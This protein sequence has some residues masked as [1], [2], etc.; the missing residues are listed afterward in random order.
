MTRAC[1]VG[2]DRGEM[3]QVKGIYIVIF[4]NLLLRIIQLS[5][6]STCPIPRGYFW[7][8]NETSACH[9]PQ[10]KCG[11]SEVRGRAMSS[12]CVV[13]GLGL[14]SSCHAPWAWPAVSLRS[15]ACAGQSSG[16]GTSFSPASGLSLAHV[17]RSL[18]N[19]HGGPLA[20]APS[21]AECK[22]LDRMGR[23]RRWAGPIEQWRIYS[24]GSGQ[25]PLAGFK[26][27]MI[28][29]KAS[30]DIQETNVEVWIKQNTEA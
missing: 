19:V 13:L 2:W 28:S 4:V 26:L 5:K 12:A 11:G 14:V 20:V 15:Q 1:A 23:G 3:D 7:E 27:R 6:Q 9:H 22:E 18:V 29:W 8:E 17:L 30:V 21:M 25:Q 24:G 16:R 10:R